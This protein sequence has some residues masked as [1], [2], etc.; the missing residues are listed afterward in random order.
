MRLDGLTER[1]GLQRRAVQRGSVRRILVALRDGVRGDECVRAAD[2]ADG[3]WSGKSKR[4]FASHGCKS[5]L[6]R[7]QN[8]GVGSVFLTDVLWIFWEV[9]RLLP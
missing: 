2:R 8:V 3:L 5:P 6:Q 7:V 9:F 1:L 4:T